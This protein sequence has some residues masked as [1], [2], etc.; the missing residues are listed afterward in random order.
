MDKDIKKKK[1]KSFLISVIILSVIF[2]VSLPFILFFIFQNSYTTTQYTDKNISLN[3]LQIKENINPYKTSLSLEILPSNYNQL[4]GNNSLDITQKNRLEI[5]TNGKTFVNIGLE[6]ENTSGVYKISDTTSNLLQNNSSY[7]L[8]SQLISFYYLNQ[9][10]NIS[11]S[12]INDDLKPKLL[13]I[14]LEIQNDMYILEIVPVF[15]KDIILSLEEKIDNT[16]LYLKN[17]EYIKS[18]NILN[19]LNTEE[20]TIFKQILARNH[21]NEDLDNL[22]EIHLL[23]NIPLIMSSKESTNYDNSWK[24]S[25]YIDE[26]TVEVLQNIK[27]ENNNQNIDLSNNTVYIESKYNLYNTIYQIISYKDKEL[28]S[29]GIDSS[30]MNNL[31]KNFENILVYLQNQEED[32]EIN[33]NLLTD[34][35]SNLPNISLDSDISINND[36]PNI[37]D[38]LLTINYQSNDVLTVSPYILYSKYDLD[39]DNENFSKDYDF[40]PT[41]QSNRSVRIPVLMYHQIENPPP[42]SSSFVQGLYVSPDIFEKQIAYLTKKNYKTIDSKEFSDILSSGQNPTQKTIMLTFDDSTSS[43]Y[44]AAYPILK[45]YGQK[46]VFFV[47]SSRTSVTY[48]QLKEMSDNGMDIE[49]H[50]SNHPDLTKVDSSSLIQQIAGSK[51]SLQHATGKTVYSIAYPGC[52]YNGTVTSIVASSG[53]SLGFSCGRSIDHYYT[54]RFTLSRVHI[55]NNMDSFVKILSGIN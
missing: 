36:I 14:L 22:N 28:K 33:S 7:L 11:N 20:E 16:I 54:N 34:I 46:G 8:N 35:I 5:L 55:F 25:E 10:Q 42:N 24:N 52:G 2:L 18:V 4:I 17:N 6:D 43:H 39:I 37:K 19:S 13:N 50:S 44:T 47:P 30:K 38:L 27:I 12:I 23:F 48:D 15:E 41:A 29:R 49:S 40:T 1:N 3:S 53:Y 31:L 9:I 45:K 21:F 26:N 32:K 51:S